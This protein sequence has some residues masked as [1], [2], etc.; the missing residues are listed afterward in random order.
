MNAQEKVLEYAHKHND[1][2]MTDQEVAG[3]MVIKG[4][5]INRTP[6]SKTFA[7]ITRQSNQIII[8][9]TTETTTHKIEN[10]KVVD[11]KNVSTVEIDRI[12]L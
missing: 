4:Y 10:G 6:N 5:V 2:T 9:E 11:Y 3:Q 1:N 8:T 7:R 12:N